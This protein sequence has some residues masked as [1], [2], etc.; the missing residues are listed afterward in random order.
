LKRQGH[1]YLNILHLKPR[2]SLMPLGPET[3]R[4]CVSC[5]R[6]LYLSLTE[7]LRSPQARRN[8]NTY[9]S[10][11]GTGS[12]D[13]CAGIFARNKGG[14]TWCKGEQTMEID[15]MFSLAESCAARFA[16]LHPLPPK[17]AGNLS[18]LGG[19]IRTSQPLLAPNRSVTWIDRCL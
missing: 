11:S 9:K 13:R 5:Q 4:W 2:Q 18:R 19:D 8:S 17:S 1:I 12:D 6:L 15:A 7:N 10:T 16:S 3:S 14:G